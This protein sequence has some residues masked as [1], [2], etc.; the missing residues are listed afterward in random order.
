M[1]VRNK[2]YKEFITAYDHRLPFT[3]F[4]PL[5]TIHVRNIKEKI[6]DK[7]ISISEIDTLIDELKR[8]PLVALDYE[9]NGLKVYADDFKAV[10]IGLA[11]DKGRVYIQNISDD[12]WTYL[13]LSLIHI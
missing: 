1:S 11:W 5:E 10:G 6:Y 12:V 8:S 9:A 2:V 3:H 7:F 13:H 4:K